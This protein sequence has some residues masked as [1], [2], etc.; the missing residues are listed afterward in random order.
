MLTKNPTVSS[1][2]KE[3][4]SSCMAGLALFSMFFG[5]G[6]L[7]FPLL[8]GKSAGEN[9][10]F[11]L[12][13][14]GITAVVMPFLGLASMILFEGNCVNFFSKI[15]TWFGGLLFFLLQLML[16]PFGVIPRLTALMHAMAK[17]YMADISLLYFSLLIAVVI[18]L[19]S[20]AQKKLVGILGAILTP[21]LVVSLATLII[22]GLVG[23]KTIIPSVQSARAS[24]LEGLFSG[25]NTMDLIAAFFFATVVLPCF[26][27]ENC[28]QDP[29]KER[30]IQLRK[31]FLASTL[32]GS[33][34]FCTYVGLSLIASYH[35]PF[36]ADPACRPEQLLSAIALRVLGSKGSAIAAF[37]VILAC[38]TTAIALAAIFAEYLRKNLCKEKVGKI[39]SLLITLAIGTVFANLGFQKILAILS[40]ILQIVYPGL[41]VLAL[42]NLSHT[43]FG[44]RI[45]KWPVYTAFFLSAALYFFKH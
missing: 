3:L 1:W 19:C 41:I 9:V 43:V 2:K 30:S 42:V 4:A 38:L 13:G 33:L 36:L 26:E 10:W 7:I 5:A 8:I 28:P 34:L 27:K 24:F 45:R 12:L 16:G 40:P 44:S 11:S 32:A 15:G 39:P 37:T 6:N 29:K 17:P 22:C 25:Y 23:E 21:L 31:I 18:F 14:L 20:F 35:G